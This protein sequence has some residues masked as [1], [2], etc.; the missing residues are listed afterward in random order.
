[1]RWEGHLASMD[2]DV[3]AKFHYEHYEDENKREDIIS[4]ILN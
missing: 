2:C 1:M 3:H 4:W